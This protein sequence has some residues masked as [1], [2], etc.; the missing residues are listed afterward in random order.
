MFTGIIKGQGRIVKNSVVKQTTQLE[1][2]SDLITASQFKQG[3]SIA[4]NGVCLTITAFT[5]TGFTVDVMPETIRRTAFSQFQSGATVNLEPAITL[6]DR[7]NGHFLLGHVDATAEVSQIEP[8]KDAQ[9]ITFKIPTEEA[10]YIVEK[11]SIGIDGV[12]LTVVGVG[13]DWFQVAL[14]PFTL[15]HTTLQ[16]L[17]IGRQ[18]NIETDILGKYVVRLQTEAEKNEK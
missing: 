2:S 15:A 12:S 8:Q 4:I 10:P 17:A 14:I 18:V 3:E 13:A 6:A 9:L 5:Q 11:G 16:A 7:L 1:I